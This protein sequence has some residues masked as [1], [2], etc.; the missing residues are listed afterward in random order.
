MRRDKYRRHS[1][2]GI[3]PERRG[4]TLEEDLQLL[5]G[6]LCAKTGFCSALAGEILQTGDPLTADAFAI[7]VLT[8]EGWPEPETEYDWRL[9]LRKLFVERY[10]NEISGAGY[11]S[12]AADR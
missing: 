7:A 11:R 5:L 12:I 8:A 3:N 2:V 9:W 1:E 10:G 6:D 4:A